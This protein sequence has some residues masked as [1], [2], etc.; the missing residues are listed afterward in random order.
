[1]KKGEINI[2]MPSDLYFIKGNSKPY[3]AFGVY[4]PNKQSEYNLYYKNFVFPYSES[5]DIEMVSDYGKKYKDFWQFNGVC[6][7]ES[8]E[9]ELLVYSPFEEL[10]ASKKATVHIAKGNM[11]E[12][13]IICIGDSMTRAGVYIKHFADTLPKV[14]PLGTK[15]FDGTLYAEGRGGWSTKQYFEIYEGENGISPFLFPKTISGDKYFGD[16][17]F[18][19]KVLGEESWFDY[20]YVGLQSVAKYLHM[21]NLDENN[22]PTSLS[23]GDVVYNNGLFKLENGKWISF[24]D[25]F[26]FNFLKYIKRY[27]KFLDTEKIDVVSILLGTNDFTDKI[28]NIGEFVEDVTDKFEKI[29]KSVKDYDKDTKVVINLPILQAGVNGGESLPPDVTV[30]RGRFN[31]LTFAEKLLEKWDN[32]EAKENGIYISPMLNI[33]DMECGFDKSYVR[34]NKYTEEQIPVFHNPV[35]PSHE[36]YKQMSDALSGVVSF[37]LQD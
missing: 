33:L 22:F 15:T 30:K 18:W 32:K 10:L 20:S 24:S 31:I 13:N 16:V 19:K 34:K 17:L 4:S 28:E 37:I 27:G 23:E 35:H 26:E 21:E 9:I 14:K 6:D 25:E 3:D 11:V 8:F 12:G 1:M 29:I 7:K 36:G 5:L 2:I